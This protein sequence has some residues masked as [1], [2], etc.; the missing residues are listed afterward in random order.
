MVETAHS[1]KWNTLDS[2]LEAILVEE[3]LIRLHQPKFNILL[4]DDKSPIYLVITGGEIPLVKTCRRTD[5]IRYSKKNKDHI[6]GPYQSGYELKK[7][8]KLLRPIF[9][10]CHGSRGKRGCFYVQLGQCSGVCT[11]EISQD[12]YKLQIT[13]LIQML[14]GKKHALLRSL[15]TQMKESASNREFEQAVRMR[16]L[17]QGIELVSTKPLE[18]DEKLPELSGTEPEEMIARLRG[19]LRKLFGLPASYPLG[20]IE[21]YDVS[22][23]HGTNSV[24]AMVVFHNGKPDNSSYRSFS[25]L[26]DGT[27]ND[28]GMMSEAII[29]RQR[30]PEWGIPHLIVID[31]GKGQIHG[32]MKA[33]EWNCPVVGIAKKPDR[34]IGW[35]TTRNAWVTLPLGNRDP[36]SR[37]LQQ[38]RDEA[39]RFSKARQTRRRSL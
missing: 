38:V 1:L 39:H 3:E 30:H 25:M 24:A 18:L 9:L 13:G 27:P 22:T 6:F 12:D 15:T 28:V 32:A 2:D 8:L 5:L 4:K 35:S 26:L 11:G 19:V 34:L 36:A 14:R 37:L 21:G 20:R 29:R 7:V 31:G 23:L 17:I 16:D 33:L 10:W